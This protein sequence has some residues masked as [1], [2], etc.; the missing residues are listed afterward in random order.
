MGKACGP[1]SLL[2]HRAGLPSSP[3]HS[4]TY[5]GGMKPSQKPRAASSQSPLLSETSMMMRSLGPGPL[6][7]SPSSKAGGTGVPGVPPL[8]LELGE[9]ERLS[10]VGVGHGVRLGLRR[11]VRTVSVTTPFFSCCRAATHN[12]QDQRSGWWLHTHHTMGRLLPHTSHFYCICLCAGCIVAIT[13]I[14]F[15]TCL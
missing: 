7:E 12:T 9:L 11:R 15:V 3:Q 4:P 6:R 2:Y 14:S 1:K 5:E 8:V 13:T 10:R